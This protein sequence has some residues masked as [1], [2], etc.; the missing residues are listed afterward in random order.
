MSGFTALA[1]QG[2]VLLALIAVAGAIIGWSFGS[3]RATRKTSERYEQ[4]LR[5]TLRRMSAAEADVVTLR[6][7][8]EQSEGTVSSQSR[9]HESR[10]HLLAALEARLAEAEGAAEEMR[11]STEATAKQQVPSHADAPVT[12]GQDNGA[13]EVGLLAEL[14]QRMSDGDVAAD[15]LTRIKGIGAVIEGTLNKIGIK[16]FAQIAA[17]SA[18]DVD[19]IEQSL[20][21]FKGRIRRDDWLTAAAALHRKE[22]GADS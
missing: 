8:L 21:S 2:V 7:N 19:L 10:E 14:A 22:H 12:G 18:D 5:A 13:A 1:S 4:Q 20:E 11:R 9:E 15:D 17:L 16:S 6:D 3:M